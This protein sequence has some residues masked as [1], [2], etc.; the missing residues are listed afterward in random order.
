VPDIDSHRRQVDHN[1]E[2]LAYLQVAGEAHADWAVTVLFYTA[3]HLI[4]QVLYH[5][6][7]INPRNHFQRH[8]AIAREPALIPIYP[9]YRELE[10]QSRRARYE[11]ARFTAEEVRRL[12]E[13]LEQIQRQVAVIVP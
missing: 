12:T 8:A 11:C 9:D 13:R 6:G 2:T 10:H 3:L 7:R 4:D 5:N 1:R